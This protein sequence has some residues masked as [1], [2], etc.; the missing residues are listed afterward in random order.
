MADASA[1]VAQYPATVAKLLE[2]ADLSVLKML[3]GDL[4]DDALRE[5]A[6]NSRLHSGLMRLAVTMNLP[7][8]SPEPVAAQHHGQNSEDGASGLVQ[9]PNREVAAGLLSALLK[10]A[11]TGGIIEKPQRQALVR[12]FGDPAIIR[13]WSALP[14][15]MPLA[16]APALAELAGLEDDQREEAC[17]ALLECLD[18]P[19]VAVRAAWT[20]SAIAGIGAAEQVRTLRSELRTILASAPDREAAA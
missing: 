14:D 11:Q 1:S 12:R 13:L 19:E 8:P 17:K 3:L 9:A 18:D 6:A 20:G 7:V 2:T 4:G 10:L 5:M 15:L 16:E